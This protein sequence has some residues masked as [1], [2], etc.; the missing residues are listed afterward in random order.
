V[1]WAKKYLVKENNNSMEQ[2]NLKFEGN[3]GTINL[4][5]ESDGCAMG[6]Y[7]DGGILE[8]DFIDGE[9]K[10]EWRNKGMEGLVQFTVLDGQLNGSWKK[11]V[12]KGPM[13]GKWNGTLIDEAEDTTEL[14]IKEESTDEWNIIHDIFSFYTFFANLANDGSQEVEKNFVQSEIKKWQFEINSV[15]YGL[16]YGN[17]QN[18]MILAD[19]VYNALYMVEGSPNKDPFIQLNE[20]HSNLAGYFNQGVLNC[21]MITTLWSSIIKLCQLRG[22]TEWQDQQLRWHLEQWSS[23]CPDLS[24]LIAILDLGEVKN[25]MAEAV[26]LEFDEKYHEAKEIILSEGAALPEI[27][28]DVLLIG[29]NRAERIF[30]QFERDGIVGPK[31]ENGKRK[32]IK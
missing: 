7:Q 10:G 25:D 5:V 26:G 27:L 22:I 8:G 3:F 14:K 30:D 21:G 23:V 16:D 6:Q 12:D 29:K 28:C 17:P 32:I 9:F 13:R 15:K 18:F 4:T 2:K 31:D 20:S 1:F 11:G 19:S 24:K